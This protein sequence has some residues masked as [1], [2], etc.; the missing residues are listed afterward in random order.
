M[1][2]LL[3]FQDILSVRNSAF[4]HLSMG[5]GLEESVRVCEEIRFHKAEEREEIHQF[6]SSYLRTGA[7]FRKQ[8]CVNRT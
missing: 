2:L 7:F 3:I 1:L 6:P 8:V 4:T 5:K